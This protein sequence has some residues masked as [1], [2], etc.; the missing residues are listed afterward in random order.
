MYLAAKQVHIEAESVAEKGGW[1]DSSGMPVLPGVLGR[2]E[3]HFVMAA[4]NKLM[5]PDTEQWDCNLK[6][7][8]ANISQNDSFTNTFHTTVMP[9]LL[10]STYLYDLMKKRAVLAGETWL[11]QGVPYPAFEECGQTRQWVPFGAIISDPTHSDY[12]S[13]KRQLELVGN[14]M[15]WAQIGT[16]FLYNIF[17]TKFK[18]HRIASS[19]GGSSRTPSA[20]MAKSAEAAKGI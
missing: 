7:C 3:G 1:I 15:H 16:W 20:G 2:L 17:T 12:V 5:D 10:R 14:S 8:V 13:P 18:P 19:Q 6:M 4:N 9:A 11:I